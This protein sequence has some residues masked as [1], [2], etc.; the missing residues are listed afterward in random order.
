MPPLSV[1]VRYVAQNQAVNG[2]LVLWR[3]VPAVSETW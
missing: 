3:I 1:T 2:V